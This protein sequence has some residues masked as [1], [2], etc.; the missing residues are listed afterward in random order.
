MKSNEV[1]GRPFP[2]P[3]GQGLKG[4]HCNMSTKST[5][6]S[7]I[8]VVLLYKLIDSKRQEALYSAKYQ[9]LGLNGQRPFLDPQLHSTYTVRLYVQHP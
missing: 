6:S 5:H 9:V 3:A 8:N 2:V 7:A 4:G 1:A